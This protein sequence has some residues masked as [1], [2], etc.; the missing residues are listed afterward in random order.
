M[1]RNQTLWIHQVPCHFSSTK[2]LQYNLRTLV[3]KE[4]IPCRK[5]S[6]IFSILLASVDMN[7]IL[8]GQLGVQGRNINIVIPQCVSSL[9]PNGR[10]YG[11]LKRGNLWV[12]RSHSG[13]C[14]TYNEQYFIM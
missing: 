6:Y 2:D 13:T 10:S 4:N 9:C 1:N 14:R 3:L 12:P 5:T 7:T 8:N 11:N